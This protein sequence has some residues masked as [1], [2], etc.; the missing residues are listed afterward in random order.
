MW[1]VYRD[2]RSKEIEAEVCHAPVITPEEDK[3]W[4]SSVFSVTYPKVLQRCVFFY[5]GKR[6][7]I[8]GG[9]EQR[10]LG[11]SNFKFVANFCDD[12]NCFVYIEHGS[13]NQC[14][15]L[16]DLRVEMKK[17]CVMLLG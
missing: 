9:Q 16:G 11:P 3:L 5:G 15:S 12:P 14:G 7:C 8:C 17:F 6:F 2:L 13:K 1:H 10:A 4:Q